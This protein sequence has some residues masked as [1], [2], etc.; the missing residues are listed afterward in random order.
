MCSQAEQG[1]HAPRQ[2]PGWEP[3]LCTKWGRD[4]DPEGQGPRGQRDDQSPETLSAGKHVQS[5]RVSPKA[6]TQ[7]KSGGK[8]DVQQLSWRLRSRIVRC[9][10]FTAWNQTHRGGAAEC[11]LTCVP[12][13]PGPRLGARWRGLVVG[14]DTVKEGEFPW[15]AQSRALSFSLGIVSRALHMQPDMC[16]CSV[17]VC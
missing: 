9:A 1:S 5:R 15:A 8:P 6:G 12:R 14:P 11:F 7:D 13:S 3:G 16:P 4:G 10:R 2:A 17:I